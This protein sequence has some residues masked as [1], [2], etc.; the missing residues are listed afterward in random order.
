[1]AVPFVKKKEVNSKHFSKTYYLMLDRKF[2]IKVAYK[3]VLNICQRRLHRT[4]RLCNR[5]ERRWVI[6]N[7]KI[8]ALHP[9]RFSWWLC[10]LFDICKSENFNHCSFKPNWWTRIAIYDNVMILNL[11]LCDRHY[12]YYEQLTGLRYCK[13]CRWKCTNGG[14]IVL[15]RQSKLLVSPPPSPGVEVPPAK[16]TCTVVLFIVYKFLWLFF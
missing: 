10:V 13:I 1:M 5:R 3:I 9:F 6:W 7:K 12:Q 4:E 8:K 15:N 2:Y 16:S 14:K 11:Y